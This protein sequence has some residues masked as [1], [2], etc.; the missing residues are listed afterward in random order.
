MLAGTRLGNDLGLAKATGKEKLTQRVVD[1]VGSR[2]VEILSLQPDGCA[3]SMFRQT[4]GLVQLAGATHPGVERAVLLPEGGVIL[5]LVEAFFKFR[6]AVHQR[7]G[8]VLS[9]KLAEALRD[10][11]V[12]GRQLSDK[13]IRIRDNAIHVHLADGLPGPSNS[14]ND[15]DLARS[16]VLGRRGAATQI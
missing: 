9:A 4:F 7:L 13:V 8:D 5:D 3:T 11:A 2:V 16:L 1:L 12:H 15:A 6:E 10:L 14:L